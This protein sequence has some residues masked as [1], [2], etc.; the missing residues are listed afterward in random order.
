VHGNVFVSMKGCDG[1]GDAVN[2]S[3]PMLPWFWQRPGRGTPSQ[4]VFKLNEPR[5]LAQ[6]EFNMWQGFIL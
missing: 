3:R 5:F 2:K 1:G 6:G 4:A